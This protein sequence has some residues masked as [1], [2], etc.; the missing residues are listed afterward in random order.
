MQGDQ[1]FESKPPGSSHHP[2]LLFEQQV[3]LLQGALRRLA[4]ALPL[5]GAG[6]RVQSVPRTHPALSYTRLQL[7]HKVLI[8]VLPDRIAGRRLVDGAG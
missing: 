7:P 4:A 2:L 5:L 6:G 1:G 8:N 3:Q